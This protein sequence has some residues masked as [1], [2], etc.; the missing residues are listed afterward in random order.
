MAS[1]HYYDEEEEE[2]VVINLNMLSFPSY[3]SLEKSPTRNGM[4]STQLAPPFHFL[5]FSTPS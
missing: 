4:E 3:L 1:L 5:L 2:D